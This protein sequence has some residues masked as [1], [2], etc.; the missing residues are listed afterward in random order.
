MIA[1]HASH[2]LLQDITSVEIVPLA[3]V[4][5]G[6]HALTV[7]LRLLADDV[8]LTDLT[9][10]SEQSRAAYWGRRIQKT[11]KKEKN[12]AVLSAASPCL[13]RVRVF[14]PSGCWLN[15]WR[16][17][18]AALELPHLRSPCSITPDPFDGAN[19]LRAFALRKGLTERDHFVSPEGL[20]IGDGVSARRQRSRAGLGA[21]IST[22][23]RGM[24]SINEGQR[25]LYD[26]PS[27]H[28]FI[29]YA[30]ELVARSGLAG[31][32][33]PAAITRIFPLSAVQLLTVTEGLAGAVCPAIRRINSL[34][35]AQM[36]AVFAAS[37]AH[38]SLGQRSAEVGKRKQAFFFSSS[39]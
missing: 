10:D 32:V 22:A 7:L 24:L 37:T 15:T 30:D 9:T 18:F 29:T 25:Y 13:S 2:C 35:A 19:S 8:S 26:L 21:T 6:P 4:G 33:T 14:D 5:A 1:S 16:R 31:A 39:V 11:S 23:T 38:H 17:S 20:H 34:S 36:E 12:V 27:T 28:A 3:I